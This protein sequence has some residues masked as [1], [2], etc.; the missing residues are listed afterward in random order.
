MKKTW[1]IVLAAMLLISMLAG[2]SGSNGASGSEDSN[3]KVTL[4]FWSFWGSET[5]RPIV[6]KMIDDYNKSQDKVV[7]KHTFV[8]WGDIWTKNLAA[9]AAGNPADV[10]VTDIND[11]SHRAKNS[12]STDLS[13]YLDDN[14]KDAFYPH[15]WETVLYKDKPYAVPFNT[16]TRMLFYN[17]KA[18]KEAGLD[19]NKPPRTWKELE[20]YAKKLDVK[21]GDT[22]ERIGFYPVWGGFGAPSWMR[23]ADGG[24]GFFDGDKPAI[25]TPAKADALT[26]L[27][28]WKKRYGKKTIEKW[29]ADFGNGTTNPFISEKVAMYTDIGTFYTQIRDSGK[30]MDFGVAPIPVYK[31]GEKPWSEGG[32]FVLEIPKGSKHPKEAADFI[33]YMTDVKAQKYWA[34][35]NYDNVAN[36]EAAE[37]VAADMKGQEKLVYEESLKNLEYT[38]L[39]PVPIEYPDYRSRIDPQIDA[40]MLGKKGAASALEKAEKDVE[41]AKK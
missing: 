37:S 38:K 26:W 33:K 39:A 9:V 19:P 35:K 31:D 21:K 2:C 15:L 25:N 7:V 23:N 18:F 1:T 16:D 4:K 34:L 27:A 30:E 6:E 24:T 20:D 17:K 29:E 13:K 10:V 40:V 5:R 32:G 28:D 22:Y 14:T 36:K 11:V 41:K 8:P 12:Q 3:G